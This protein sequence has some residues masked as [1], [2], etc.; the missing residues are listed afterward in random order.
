MAHS[1]ANPKSGG[2]LSDA[3]VR[4]DSSR[5]CLH[6][7]DGPRMALIEGSLFKALTL[8]EDRHEGLASIFVSATTSRVDVGVELGE[9]FRNASY[10]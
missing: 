10:R 8:T 2:S 5:N 1:N 7:F 9:D 6:W 4:P 3:A